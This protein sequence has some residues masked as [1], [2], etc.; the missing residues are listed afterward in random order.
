MYKI[1]FIKTLTRRTLPYFQLSSP[2]HFSQQTLRPSPNTPLPPFIQQQHSHSEC[3]WQKEIL[4]GHL[5]TL[6]NIFQT[7]NIAEDKDD[8]K[9]ER[10]SG[11]DIPV[12]SM[13]VEERRV[14]EDGE[15]ACADRED[16]EPLPVDV[17]HTL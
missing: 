1:I 7:R 16:V 14:L 2:S 8:G 13:L 11:E 17:S 9:R 3:H 4:R 15:A 6:K 10:D 12:L 5:R